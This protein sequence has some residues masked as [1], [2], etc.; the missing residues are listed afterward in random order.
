MDIYQLAL[1]VGIL[2]N[3]VRLGSFPHAGPEISVDT[4]YTPS[5]SWTSSYL[6]NLPDMTPSLAE[7]PVDRVYGILDKEIDIDKYIEDI[8]GR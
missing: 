6:S 1:G 7:D 8:R 5:Q 2:N 4:I 3:L